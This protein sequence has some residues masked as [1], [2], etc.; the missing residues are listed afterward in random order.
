M[1]W[2]FAA[3]PEVEQV[4]Y[5]ESSQSVVVH[6]N[7]DR[8]FGDIAATL[9]AGE[10]APPVLLSPA[11]QVDWSR[12]AAS[13]LLSLLPLGPVG[14]LALALATSLTEE[15]SRG[16]AAA[17]LQGPALPPEGRGVP[18]PSTAVR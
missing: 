11:R 15:L 4:S 8:R 14:S 18:R 5:R 10:V 13:C 7:R 6:F 3:H 16:R 17:T 2:R 12:V 1:A 9:P